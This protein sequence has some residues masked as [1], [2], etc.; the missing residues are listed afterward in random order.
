MEQPAPTRSFLPERDR[1][2]SLLLFLLRAGR[3][4]QGSPPSE[5]AQRPSGR[6]CLHTVK[7]GL[8][9]LAVVVKLT[10]VLPRAMP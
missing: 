2:L 8:G 7:T 4:L 5:E 6:L 9:L 3:S 1:E 10:A